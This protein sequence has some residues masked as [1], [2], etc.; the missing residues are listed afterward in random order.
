LDSES[1]RNDRTL[2]EAEEQRPTGKLFYL[3]LLGGLAAYLLYTFDV[4][5]LIAIA[6][7]A[8]GLT[9]V[10]F[11]HELGHFAVAKWCDVHVEAFSIG[12]GP[13]LPGCSFRYGETTYMIGA[14]PLGGYVKMVGEGPDVE[15]GEDD[16]RSFKNKS[17][18]QRMA[19]ISAGVTMNLVLALA[20]FVFVYRTHGAERSPGVVDGVDPGS[21]AWKLGVKSGDVIQWIGNRGPYPYFDELRPVVMNSRENEKLNFVWGPP[22]APEGQVHHAQIE[23]KKTADD[24]RPLIGIAPPRELKLVPS[25]VK[26]EHELP[27]FFQSAAARA[28]P[29]FEF[30]DEIVGTTDPQD[31]TR[32]TEL[33]PDPDPRHAGFRDYFAFLKRMEELADQ[34]IV[35]RVVREKRGKKETVDIHVP[36]A[37]HWV[38]GMRMR[39]GAI[40]A[41][42][43]G[44]SAA[45]AGILRT[46]SST[47]SKSGTGMARRSAF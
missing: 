31:P 36:A 13:A 47:A 15:D 22:N 21:P 1:N 38:L 30:G 33:P 28:Q 45:K 5:G 10:V 27:V 35:L 39:M 29:P 37:Y 40:T 17:V 44:S 11:V 18:W 34:P 23:P 26:K 25:E 14:L 9:F 4:D 46:T 8:L 6:K 3:F 43:D 7:T 19:I 32:V 24:S 20:C 12:F 16:P 41:V 42:R 2:S